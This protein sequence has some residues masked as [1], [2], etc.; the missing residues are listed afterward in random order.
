MVAHDANWISWHSSRTP[1]TPALLII[2]LS[3][4][5]IDPYFKLLV[6]QLHLGC[7][8]YTDF[9]LWHND[10]IHYSIQP[11]SSSFASQN[12]TLTI[13]QSYC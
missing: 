4:L 3:S 10:L 8:A 9:S 5:W 2:Y 1:S 12:L 11:D 6:L 13:S 7:C